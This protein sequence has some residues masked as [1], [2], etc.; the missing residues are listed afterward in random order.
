MYIK[1]TLKKWHT[2]PTASYDAA[3]G[4][5]LIKSEINKSVISH[6]VS[7]IGG[8][9]RI[10]NHMFKTSTAIHLRLFPFVPATEERLLSLISS[11]DA[12]I[13]GAPTTSG[14]AD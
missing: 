14:G 8:F 5:S 6:V 12:R 10:L 3:G 11:G 4:V 7:L 13:S 9:M 1:R 2:L